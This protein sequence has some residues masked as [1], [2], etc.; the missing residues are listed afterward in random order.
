MSSFGVTVSVQDLTVW[1]LLHMILYS[2]EALCAQLSLLRT[3][4]PII[5]KS[6]SPTCIA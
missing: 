2:A 3:V 4:S 1:L 6:Q 5:I